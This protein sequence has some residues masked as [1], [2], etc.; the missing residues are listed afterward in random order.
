MASLVNLVHCS[1]VAVCERVH[2]NLHYTKIGD[3]GCVS[4]QNSGQ[5]IILK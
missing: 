3:A 5:H 4:R 2:Y 1:A